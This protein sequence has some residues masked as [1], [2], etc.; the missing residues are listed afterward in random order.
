MEYNCNLI[1]VEEKN[2]IASVGW[3]TLC[4]YVL[5][6][7]E[8]FNDKDWHIFFTKFYLKNK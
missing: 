7:G 5:I 6:M 8:I 3:I 1:V 2:Y 4:F